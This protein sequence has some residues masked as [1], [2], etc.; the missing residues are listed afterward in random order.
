MQI[1]RAKPAGERHRVQGVTIVDLLV[2]FAI[3]AVLISLIVPGIQTAREVARRVQCKNNLHH[4][5]IAL[6]ESR[7]GGNDGLPD[8]VSMNPAAIVDAGSDVEIFFAIAIASFLPRFVQYS[9][10]Y[11]PCSLSAA[12]IVGT[13]GPLKGMASD[14]APPH[15]SGVGFVLPAPRRFNGISR[16]TAP[17]LPPPAAS[18]SNCRGRWGSGWRRELMDVVAGRDPLRSR[19]NG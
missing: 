6:A 15:C 19:R 14:R 16:F 4:I 9:G 5:G 13:A 2:V 1:F 3:I 7:Q 12:S 11:S 17:S 18:R 10:A 8:E